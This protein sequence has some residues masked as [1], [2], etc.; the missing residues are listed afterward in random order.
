VRQRNETYGGADAKK[1]KLATTGA[2]AEETGRDITTTERRA[3]VT[4]SNNLKKR[5]D[6]MADADHETQL[7]HLKNT[8]TDGGKVDLAK[9]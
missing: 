2:A 1:R 7:V 6:E 8:V 5:Q 4:H 9:V 3:G